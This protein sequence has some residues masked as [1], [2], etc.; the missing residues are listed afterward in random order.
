[1]GKC[2]GSPFCSTRHRGPALCLQQIVWPGVGTLHWGMSA[3]Q[4][5]TFQEAGMM[6]EVR[7]MVVMSKLSGDRSALVTDHP[8]QSRHTSYAWRKF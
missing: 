8:C 7:L 6:L 1:M 3:Q 4:G 2:W 5:P